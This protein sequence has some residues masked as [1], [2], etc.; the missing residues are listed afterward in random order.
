VGRAK[1]GTSGRENVGRLRLSKQRSLCRSMCL[2]LQHFTKSKQS[3]R[4]VTSSCKVQRVAFIQQAKDLLD[5]F[6]RRAPN[7]RYLQQLQNE[8]IPVIHG[9][10]H[11]DTTFFQQD[12]A[13][14]RTANVALDVLYDVFGSYA[15][16]I[17]FQ[18]ASYV[19]GPSHQVHRT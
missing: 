17:C 15:C 2:L 19:G 13:R 5:R 7:Q 11:V 10:G 9:R 1:G 3:R 8:V 14:P 18:N 12:D 4:D 6:L 16:L